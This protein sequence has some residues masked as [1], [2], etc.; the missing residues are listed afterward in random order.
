M[1]NDAI[2]TE[3]TLFRYP[4]VQ[5]YFVRFV[6]KRVLLPL[7]ITQNDSSDSMKNKNNWI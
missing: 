5:Y 7:L 1:K 3:N 4:L 6:R 2:S